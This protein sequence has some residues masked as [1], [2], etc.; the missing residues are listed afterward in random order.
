MH[1]HRECV[2]VRNNVL[3]YYFLHDGVPPRTGNIRRRHFPKGC[4]SIPIKGTTS[5]TTTR[6]GGLYYMRVTDLM[7]TETQYNRT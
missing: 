4:G 6:Y 1:L 5:V 7:F 2:R 3:Y